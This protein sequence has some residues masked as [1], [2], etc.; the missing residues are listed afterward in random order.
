MDCRCP[1]RIQGTQ[2]ATTFSPAKLCQKHNGSVSVGG[3]LL[4]IVMPALQLR[5]GNGAFELKIL[6]R[7]LRHD[8]LLVMQCSSRHL[9]TRIAAG[10]LY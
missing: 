9:L 2:D 7:R 10:G 4:S 5:K 3:R 8:E 6:K 1:A